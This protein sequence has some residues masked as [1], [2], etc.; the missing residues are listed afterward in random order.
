MF[1]A[2]ENDCC[3]A[4]T[5]MMLSGF[6]VSIIQLQYF[7]VRWYNDINMSVK[8]TWHHTPDSQ[9]LDYTNNLLYLLFPYSCRTINSGFAI[10]Q[11]KC[12]R[13]L[14]LMAT[15]GRHLAKRTEHKKFPFVLSQRKKERHKKHAFQNVLE[16]CA[17]SSTRCG[18]DKR[19]HLPLALMLFPNL[20]MGAFRE[21]AKS[22]S[23]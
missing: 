22:Q 19:Q 13:Y 21:P 9:R 10:F 20:E 16:W 11:D 23:P 14:V 18:T 12:K 3:W 8:Y 7:N 5:T 17:F 6:S 1:S 2:N 15:L 4:T